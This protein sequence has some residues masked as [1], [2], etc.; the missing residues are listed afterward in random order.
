MRQK[1]RGVAFCVLLL[2]W[3]IPD[4]SPGVIGLTGQLLR[5]PT[6]DVILDTF[7]AFSLFLIRRVTF[8]YVD[9]G[10]LMKLN[11]R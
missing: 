1:N 8:T 10:V 6:I 7:A 9:N 2:W 5:V 3:L 11:M 4:D